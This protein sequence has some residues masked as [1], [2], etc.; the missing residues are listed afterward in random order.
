VELPLYLV[1]HFFQHKPIARLFASCID[2]KHLNIDTWGR[3]LDTLYASGVTELYSLIAAT[4][5]RRLGLAP[6]FAHLDSTSFHVDGRYSSE[7]E[8]EEQVI[9]ITRGYSRDHRPDL[10][11]GMLDLMIEH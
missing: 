9:H 8:P 4:A 6:T 5:A 7:K 1:P 10:N 2:A 11:Q 3:A